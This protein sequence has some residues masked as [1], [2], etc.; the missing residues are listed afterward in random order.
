M[1][2]VA[3]TTQHPSH[4]LAPIPAVDLPD[5]IY[6]SHQLALDHHAQLCLVVRWHVSASSSVLCVS[7]PLEIVVEAIQARMAGDLE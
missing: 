4:R 7:L 2:L 1:N 3:G 6:L 5:G